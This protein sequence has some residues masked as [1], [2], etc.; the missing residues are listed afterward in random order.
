M[1]FFRFY[2]SQIAAPFAILLLVALSVSGCS[3]MYSATATDFNS[4]KFKANEGIVFLSLAQE[5][6]RFYGASYS[7][8][9]KNDADGG[10]GNVGFN[11]ILLDSG[12]E[13]LADSGDP[14][15]GSVKAYTLPAGKYRFYSFSIVQGQYGGYSSWEPNEDFS[16]PFT[17][18]P[19]RATYL[20]RITM[21]PVGGRN[22]FGV[23]MLAGGV[24]EI[25]SHPR[26][27]LALFSGK[28][29]GIDPGLIVKN[30]LRSGNVPSEII[31]FR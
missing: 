3:Y 9:F 2:R 10:T 18:R 14:V 6:S 29:P 21:I 22:I 17:V 8:Y 27:D 12:N 13:N 24:F 1:S 5:K 11:T 23:P 4:S 30:Q 7:F 26:R 19:G 16:I 15:R 25:S 31:T 28:Y 20:G